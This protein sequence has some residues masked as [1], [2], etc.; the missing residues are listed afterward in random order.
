LVHDADALAQARDRLAR[1]KSGAESMDARQFFGESM[2]LVERLLT[3]LRGMP[4]RERAPDELLREAKG[5]YT[6][7]QLSTARRLLKD[8]EAAVYGGRGDSPE[9]RRR[10]LTALEALVDDLSAAPKPAAP[11]ASFAGL[12]GLLGLGGA[13]LTFAHPAALLAAIPVAAAAYYL[14]KR[15]AG[16]AW[17]STTA[18]AAP[19]KTGLRARL[20]FATP[21][22]RWAAVALTLLALAGPQMGVR[23]SETYV[24]STDTMIAGDISGSMS[25]ER[26]DGLKRAIRAYLVEQRRGTHNRVGFLTFSD[27]AYLA[28]SLTTDYDALNSRAQETQTDGSTAIGKAILASVSHFLELNIMQ[29]DASDPD[30][31]KMREMVLKQDLSGALA[32]AKQRPGLLD[33]VLQPE[34]TKIVVLFTDGESNSGIEPVDAAK[35]AKQLGIKVYTVGIQ[36]DAGEQTLKDVA[37]LTGGLYYRAED[38]DGM[39]NALLDISRLEKSP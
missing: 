8:G 6:E 39:R 3:D 29:L 37:A 36:I 25:G 33:R 2:L 38:A 1:L 14:W 35:I 12:A 9:A 7:G 32:Y 10:T 30:V 26:L 34:R 17:S 21:T 31:A 22:L 28:V 5:L 16:S 23:R 11:G 27:D 4:R 13:G 15:R 20:R 19:A 24:P 18:S